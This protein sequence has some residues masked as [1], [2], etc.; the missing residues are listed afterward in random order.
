MVAAN[1]REE[2]PWRSQWETLPRCFPS[3]HGNLQVIR[4]NDN[5][6]S[7]GTYHLINKDKE[8][9]IMLPLMLYIQLSWK[10]WQM[11]F[12]TINDK[13]YPQARLVNFLIVL[14]NIHNGLTICHL[15]SVASKHIFYYV[16]NGFWKWTD[17]APHNCLYF[18]SLKYTPYRPLFLFCDAF[19]QTR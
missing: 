14:K 13:R 2:L 17:M 8:L 3:S 19:T 1:Q 12:Q 5:L 18:V 15:I 7:E 16:L 9:E 6:R 10:Q 11:S 4:S